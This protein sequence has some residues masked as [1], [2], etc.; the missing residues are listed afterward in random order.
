MRIGKSIPPTSLV[1]IGFSTILWMTVYGFSD[2][3]PSPIPNV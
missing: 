2:K 3:L 1:P